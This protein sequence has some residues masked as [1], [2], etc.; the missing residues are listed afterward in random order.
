MQLKKNNTK[1]KLRGAYYTPIQLANE[2]VSLFASEKISSVLEPSCGD[3][4]FLAGDKVI[5]AVEAGR[6]CIGLVQQLLT[7]RLGFRLLRQCAK[8]ANKIVQTRTQT[9]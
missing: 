7:Q 8:G 3:G 5:H 1:Q 6:Q 9:G 2:M 4:V